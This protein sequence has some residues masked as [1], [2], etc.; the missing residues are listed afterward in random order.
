MQ[1]GPV[2]QY[3]GPGHYT[4][5]LTVS[6]AYTQANVTKLNYINITPFV[7]VFPG[8]TELPTDPDGDYLVEDI[9]GN[10]RLDFDDV[11]AYYQNMEWIRQQADVGIT[12]YDFNH[13]GRIDYDDLVLLYYIVL[14]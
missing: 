9:N 4:V 14:G 6:N 2:V 1:S 12:P 7:K 11:V 10:G 5:N 13:N 3:N 8:Y